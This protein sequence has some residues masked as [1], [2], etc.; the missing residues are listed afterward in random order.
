MKKNNAYAY[1][2]VSGKGQISGNGFHRQLKEIKRYC[3]SSSYKIVRVYKEQISGT[4]CEK[5]RP[6]MAM[7]VAD[8][9]SDDCRT[10]IVEDLTRLA[11]EYRVQENILIYL[12]SKKIDL[13]SANTGEN[14][15]EAIASDPM[16][17]A[18]VQV[19]GIFGE[20][21]KS[22]LVKKLRKAREKIRQEEG[23]CEGVKPYGHLEGEAETLKYIKRLRR[24]PKNS[25]RKRR[26]YQSIAEH[27]NNKGIRPRRGEVWT[28]SLVYNVLK[29]N[30]RRK[31]S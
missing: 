13:I 11:Q 14:I 22:M 30:N 28:P 23:R 6:E 5:Q 10:I 24:K 12:A 15:T 9:L 27:L 16:R 17:K 31:K 2:R 3:K 18:L 20:L 19:Q 29:P 8:I 26:T 1:L 25:C 21:D 7:M 4:I